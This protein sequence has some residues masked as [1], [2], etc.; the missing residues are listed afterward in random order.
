MESQIKPWYILGEAYR[1]VRADAGK[2][3]GRFAAIIIFFVA[4]QIVFGAIFLLSLIVSSLA[5]FAVLYFGLLYADGEEFTLDALLLKL[6]F[7]L[8]TSFFITSLLVDLAI[9]GGFILFVIPSIIVMVQLR[10]AKFLVLEKKTSPRLALRESVQLTK[11]HRSKILE[12]VA[13][14]I[15]INGLGLFCFFIGLFITLPITFIGLALMYRK[16]AGPVGPEIVSQKVKTETVEAE[17][18]EPA[19]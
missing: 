14:A 2:I 19:E 8:F 17:I 16:I 4:G 10:F 12:Y 15:L 18:I 7:R 11:G 9:L 3:I 5:S 1:I 13:L 6:N